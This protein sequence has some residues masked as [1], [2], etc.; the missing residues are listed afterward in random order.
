MS[1]KW[2]TF[3]PSE[4]YEDEADSAIKILSGSA[5]I[6]TTFFLESKTTGIW[7]KIL[8]DLDTI[9]L[10]RFCSAVPIFPESNNSRI[11]SIAG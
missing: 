9:F 7:L 2:E 4:W 1:P 6:T 11:L 3:Q 10:K 8:R 5:A